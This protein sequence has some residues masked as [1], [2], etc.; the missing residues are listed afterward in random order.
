MRTKNLVL[1]L[2]T[3]VAIAP[4]ATIAFAQLSKHDQSI[5]QYNY[6]VP[7]ATDGSA[8]V[9]SNMGSTP[10]NVELDSM[11]GDAPATN[12]MSNNQ[13]MP[14]AMPQPMQQAPG[15]MM[16][17]Q[18]QAQAP[19]TPYQNIQP[20]TPG[21]GMPLPDAPQ[22]LQVPNGG[23]KAM[24]PSAGIQV[25]AQ[26]PEFTLPRTQG[27][28]LALKEILAKGPVVILFTRGSSCGFCVNQMQLLQK[29][30]AQFAALG[31]Q[32]VAVSPEPLDAL[33]RAQQR[34]GL[35]Y[36]ML[37]DFNMQATAM[38]GLVTGNSMTP[39]M[40]TLDA[41]GKVV[42]VQTER[43]GVGVFNLT[44]ATNPLR[45]QALV[46][47][48]AVPT[49]PA[50]AVPSTQVAPNVLPPAMP[51]VPSPQAGKVSFDVPPSSPDFGKRVA[52]GSISI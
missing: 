31:I 11:S 17:G 16:Q 9:S 29:N 43:P 1:A 28:V 40:V 13:M 50:T 22:Q 44:Q 47:P 8:S 48:V 45:S 10:L 32:T 21:Y 25:G 49:S 19:L 52:D 33:A 23:M 20:S 30:Q 51:P 42:D 15:M 2:L 26:A 46:A 4:F 35:T 27:P 38:Y 41:T 18:G 39:A 5:A 37:S 24:A 34:F 36:T 12:Q 6:N 3:S 14:P 7:I